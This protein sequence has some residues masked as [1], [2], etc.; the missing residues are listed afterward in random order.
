VG[1]EA[2]RILE[3]KAAALN[4]FTQANGKFLLP[5]VELTE[6]ARPGC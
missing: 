2:Q 1:R 3:I 6:T 5:L 4:Q